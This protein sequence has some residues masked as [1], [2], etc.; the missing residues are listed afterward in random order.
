MTF[1]RVGSS[2]PSG[3]DAPY[4][5]SDEDEHH[6]GGGVSLPF[7]LRVDQGHKDESGEERSDPVPTT[8]KVRCVER[9]R[10]RD[11]G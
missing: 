4:Q 10:E 2:L 1:R 5:K 7:T 8:Q 11:G 6:G 3:T 9:E